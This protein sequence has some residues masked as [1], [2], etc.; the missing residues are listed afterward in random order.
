MTTLPRRTYVVCAILYNPSAPQDLMTAWR[1]A[2]EHL[3]ASRAEDRDLLVRVPRNHFLRANLPELIR[4]R[5]AWLGAIRWRT[6]RELDRA[7]A[8]LMDIVPIHERS[9]WIHLYV[10]EGG[11]CLYAHPITSFRGA[12]EVLRN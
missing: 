4:L 1:A 11:R 9:G 7:F 12:L 6:R 10:F 3:A 5:L 8:E 2:V